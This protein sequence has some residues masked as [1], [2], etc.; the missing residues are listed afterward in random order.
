MIQLF[1]SDGN[2]IGLFEDFDELFHHINTIETTKFTGS[3]SCFD[4]DIWSFSLFTNK[5]LSYIFYKTLEQSFSKIGKEAFDQ[6]FDLIEISKGDYENPLQIPVTPDVNIEDLK[7][8][9]CY[10]YCDAHGYVMI[11]YSNNFGNDPSLSVPAANIIGGIHE[12]AKE[13]YAGRCAPL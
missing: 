1:Q 5:R 6:G 12:A 3:S 7:K 4:G 10:E 9:W 8:N 11:D 2:V 13:R